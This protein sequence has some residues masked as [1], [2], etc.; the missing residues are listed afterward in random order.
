VV[1]YT[2]GGKSP[3]G[4]GRIDGGRE[5]GEGGEGEGEGVSQYC[6]LV[7]TFLFNVCE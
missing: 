2:D 6:S 5:R 4:E 3:F 7:P 1:T